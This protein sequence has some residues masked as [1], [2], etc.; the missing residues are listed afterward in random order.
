MARIWWRTLKATMEDLSAVMFIFCTSDN[1]PDKFQ[2]QV[3][4]RFSEMIHFFAFLL[5]KLRVK[6][7]VVTFSIRDLF[8][9][10]EE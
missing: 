3:S 6:L 5:Q 4:G 2:F 8:C 7:I 9:L 1:S 10:T